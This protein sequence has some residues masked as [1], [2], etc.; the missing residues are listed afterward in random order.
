MKNKGWVVLVVVICAIV[1]LFGGSYNSLQRADENVNEK[2]AQPQG[3]NSFNHYAYG[4]VCE[5]MWETMKHLHWKALFL[6]VGMG[7]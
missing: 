6:C 3:M 5:W 7:L 2:W 4:C 1:L